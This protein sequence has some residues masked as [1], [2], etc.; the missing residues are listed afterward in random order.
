[1]ASKKPLFSSERL[2]LITSKIRDFLDL[3]SNGSEIGLWGWGS[4]TAYII[5]LYIKGARSGPLLNLA[6]TQACQKAYNVIPL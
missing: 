4:V 5:N 3:F 6:R 1:M 2:K